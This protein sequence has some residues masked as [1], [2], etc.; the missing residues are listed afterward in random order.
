MA[1]YTAIG[2]MSGTS[3]DGLDIVLVEFTKH[4]IWSFDIL[5]SKTY[6]YSNNLKELLSTAENLP[7]KE[8]LLFH[9]NY[10]KYIGEIVKDFLIDEKSKP[11]IIASH[12]HTIF[13][14]PEKKFTYQI[15]NGAEIA[16]ET[17]ITTVSDFRSL[18]IALNGQGA[19]LVPIGDKLLFA[20]Y[21]YCLNIGGFANISFTK[22]NKRKA[23]D[24][25]PANIIANYL[26]NKIER[27]YDNKGGLGSSGIINNKLLSELNNIEFYS[28]SGPKSLGKE[29]LIKEFTPI[30]DNYD[31]SV[32]DKLSTIYEHIAIQIAKTTDK[33]YKKKILITGGGAYN[34]FLISRIKHHSSNEIIIPSN[35]II[36]FK[37]ALIFAFLGILRTRNEINTLASVTGA[38]KDSSG[39]IIHNI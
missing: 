26:C 31:I 7:A 37:E 1:K 25:C 16:K 17:S 21:D 9:N 19:P 18:D 3:L 20:K 8:F 33:S 24:I 13:H 38:S 29:W 22:N 6:N 2:I 23:F 11:D 5:K 36:D 39:G 12:G 34:D 14:Q 28:K 32:S 30:I 15:G 35:E 10:G 27:Q 4:D